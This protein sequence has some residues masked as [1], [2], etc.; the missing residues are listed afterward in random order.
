M[1]LSYGSGDG[2]EKPRTEQVCKFWRGDDG[3]KKGSSCACTHDTADMK[4]R[5]FACGG[6]H[7]KKDCPHQQ[8]GE[9]SDYKK[10][11]KGEDHEGW[12]EV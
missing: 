9:K 1:A 10:G 2:E 12:G 5:C 8:K 4:G 11:V 3:C 6:L 7:M